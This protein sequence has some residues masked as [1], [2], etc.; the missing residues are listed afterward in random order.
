MKLKSFDHAGYRGAGALSAPVIAEDKTGSNVN[1]EAAGEPGGTATLA[2]AYELYDMGVASGDALTVLT[3]AKRR[4]RSRPKRRR[5]EE[6]HRKAPP[7]PMTQKATQ[8]RPAAGGRDVRH[9]AGT[10]R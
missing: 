3:A 5:A 8:R 10:G 6:D 7:P 1:T 9:G 4:L 2:L